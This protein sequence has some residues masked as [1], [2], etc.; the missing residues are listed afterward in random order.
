[1]PRLKHIEDRIGTDLYSVE[2]YPPGYFQTFDPQRTFQKWAAV[3]VTL[4]SKIPEPFESLILPKGLYAIFKYRGRMGPISEFYRWIYTEWITKSGHI[5]DD[6]PHI[7]IMDKDF[8]Q[9][10]PDCWERIC[11][12]LLPTK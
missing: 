11:I 3:P 10:D 5:L 4:E 12:P 9:G 7:A 6:R 1:M 8:R 2:V